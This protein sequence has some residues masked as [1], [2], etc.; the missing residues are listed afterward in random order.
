MDPTD[1]ELEHA[2]TSTRD[3]IALFSDLLKPFRISTLNSTANVYVP[4]CI[5]LL[6]RL[7]WLDKMKDWL[8]EILQSYGSTGVPLERYHFRERYKIGFHD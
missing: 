2:L 5:G 3:Q 7:P 8:C 4:R 6:S 1:A